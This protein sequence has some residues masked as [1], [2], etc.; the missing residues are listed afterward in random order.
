[1]I[2]NR[3]LLVVTGAAV[4]VAI[5]LRPT[6]RIELQVFWQ[7]TDAEITEKASVFQSLSLDESRQFVQIPVGG[8]FVRRIRIDPAPHGDQFSSVNIANVQITGTQDG[9]QLSLSVPPV[10][11]CF[12][13]SLETNSEGTT[14]SSDEKDPYILSEVVPYMKVDS[15]SFEFIG[16][17]EQ[18]R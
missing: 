4:I 7:T 1:M 11:Y 16:S 9:Q 15:L 3:N 2:S 13:C 14:I 17:L 12:N 6:D 18:A 5:F 10:W 8:K